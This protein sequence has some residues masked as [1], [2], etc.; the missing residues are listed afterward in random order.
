MKELLLVPNSMQALERE[1]KLMQNRLSV[2]DLDEVKYCLGIQTEHDRDNETLFLQ[3]RKYPSSLLQKF[4]MDDCK[5]TSTPQEENTEL[6]VNEREP[7]N[8]V[9]YQ[10]LVGIITYAGSITRPYLAR[11][12]ESI[13]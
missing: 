11:A 8:K 3:Q 10:A 4:G 5:A 7:I 12:F 6:T 9:E 1:K 2:K 13:S